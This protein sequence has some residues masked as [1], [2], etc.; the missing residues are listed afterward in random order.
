MCPTVP[1]SDPSAPP[2]NVYSLLLP[3]P[4][5]I[6]MSNEQPVVSPLLMKPKPT[7]GLKLAQLDVSVSQ[8]CG[9]PPE[10][11]AGRIASGFACLFAGQIVTSGLALAGPVLADAAPIRAGLTR[12]ALADGATARESTVITTAVMDTARTRNRARKRS[13]ITV[14]P[15]TKKQTERSQTKSDEKHPGTRR[16][17]PIIA[18][19]HIYS[20][21]AWHATPA[22]FRSGYM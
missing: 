8:H 21:T 10:S 19:S 13:H 7:A 3:S 6:A 5:V 14:L 1:I 22:M 18:G 17:I 16:G 12:T 11:S 2:A 9:C 20:E 4:Q 15:P